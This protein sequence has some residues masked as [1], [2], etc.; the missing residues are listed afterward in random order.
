MIGKFHLFIIFLGL[1]TVISCSS[2]IKT[3][4]KKNEITLSNK[5]YKS[6]ISNLLIKVPVGWNEIKDNTNRLI[7]F[8]M[9]SP[10]KT[11]SIIF[12]PIN[13]NLTNEK[14]SNREKLKF[15]LKT[16][17]KIL[18]NT[19]QNFT[20]LNKISPYKIDNIRFNGFTYKTGKK[21]KRII[22]FGNGNKFFECI[23]YYNKDYEATESEIEN[24]FKTQQLVLS[25][26]KIK[27]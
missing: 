1:F 15:L 21:E 3:I 22:L 23:A 10:Q 17:Y 5:Y 9:V 6:E 24:L 20:L 7:D 14:F 12:I 16:K 4:N 2:A 11:S 27:N 8:W 25:T 13:L 26:I 19:S 18:Q